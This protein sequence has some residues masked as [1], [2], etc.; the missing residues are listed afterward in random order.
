LGGGG[1]SR[2]VW[3]CSRAEACTLNFFLIVPRLSRGVVVRAA[4]WQVYLPRGTE[5]CV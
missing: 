1:C 5:M 3:R 2:Q 4:W